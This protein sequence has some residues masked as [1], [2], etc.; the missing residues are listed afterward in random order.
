MEL[1]LL[2]FFPFWSLYNVK[3][4]ANGATIKNK[5]QALNLLLPFDKFSR[6]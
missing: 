2:F 5:E 4:K 1:S 6:N 3:E